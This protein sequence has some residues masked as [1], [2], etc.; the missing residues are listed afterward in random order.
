LGVDI[1]I[2]HVDEK[3]SAINALGII[4]MHAPILCFGRMQ[5]ILAALERNQ[6]FFHENVKFHTVLAY[7]QIGLGLMKKNGVCDADDK[8]KWT[9][10]APSESPLPQE[11][12][13]YFDRIV[14]P[15]FFE[16]F[17]SEENKEVIER[18]LE[19]MREMVIDFGPAVF[20]LHAP[21]VIE[22]IIAFLQKKTFCQSGEFGGDDEVEDVNPEEDEDEPEEEDDGIDHDEIILGNVSDLILYWA[23]ALGNDFAN[24]FSQ[25]AAPLVEYTKDNHPK[26]DK[27]CAIG[28]IAEVFA[29]APGI[30]PAYFD[31]F[32][33]ILT[34]NADLKDS[35]VNRNIA[36]SIGVLAQH[37]QLLF[38]PHLSSFQTLLEKLHH[39]SVEQEAKDN[40]VAAYSR[41]IEHQ[42]MPLPAAQRPPNYQAMVHSVMSAMPLEG[43]M[44]ENETLLKFAWKLYAADQALCL[45]YMDNVSKTCVKCIIDAKCADDMAKDFK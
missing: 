5:E 31:S 24:I 9:K 30:I 28:C 16:L 25:V 40:I 37:A 13:D 21:K 34:S 44:T 22:C 20:V 17:K 1:D 14:I 45:Q 3:A 7:M 19:N 6:Q 26:S 32:I 43:D 10:G 18:V 35:K 36:Y 39:D 8:F 42:Y 38:Q 15:Y 4:S 41:I 29:A 2:S 23:R 27:N 11:V 12:V 33:P